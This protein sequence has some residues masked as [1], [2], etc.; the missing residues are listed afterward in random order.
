MVASTA[1]L[2]I[3]PATAHD[4][5]KISTAPNPNFP[6]ELLL[7]D[8]DRP[9][10][11]NALE[12]MGPTNAA[13]PLMETAVLNAI[14]ACSVFGAEASVAAANPAEENPPL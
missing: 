14:G 13:T 9:A 4:P 10:C 8:A 7:K 11:N 12:T 2:D 6:Y 1:R 5:T 3:D